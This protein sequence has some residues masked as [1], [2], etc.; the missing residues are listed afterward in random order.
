[1][2]DLFRDTALGQLIRWVSGKKVLLYPEEKPDFQCPNCYSHPDTSTDAP[3]SRVSSHASRPRTPASAHARDEPLPDIET[4]LEGRTPS[5]DEL[6]LEKTHT[7]MIEH[8]GSGQSE[9]S[10]IVSRPNFSSVKSH[11][12]L[13]RTFSQA[14]LEKGP[15]RPI[16]PSKLD[17]GTILVDW[18]TTDD[19]ANPQNWSAWK[20]GFVSF[21]I[22]VYTMAVYM[23]SAIYTPSI[24]GVVQR[25]GVSETAASLG[26]ALYVLAYGIGPLLF[27]PISEIPV[28][29]RNPPYIATFCLFVVLSVPTA[30]VDNF[31]G[32]LVLRF[33]M[34]FFGSPCLATGG[35]SMQDMFNILKLPYM[36]CFWVSAAT[37][38]PALGP[39]IA[40][41]SVAAE[42]WRWSLW[43]ILWL[44]GPIFIL[45]FVALPET[46]TPNILLRRARRLRKLTGDSRLK[47]QSEI[48]QG[49]TKV[50]D[51]V[52]DSLWKP[53]Q[54]AALDPAIAFADFY[55]SLVYAIYYSFFE[56]FPLVFPVMYNFNLGEQGLAF[57]S[58]TVSVSLAVMA[59]FVYLYWW[60]E[61]EIK[62]KGLQ[63]PEKRLVPALYAAFFLPVG[64]FMFGWTA[65]PSVHWIAPIIG[66]TIY[67]FGVF[68]VFQCV[69]IYIPLSYLPYAASLFAGNDFL[70]SALAA[71]A[72]LF[73]RPMYINLGVGAGV[74]LLAGL[75]CVCVGGIFALYIFGAKLRAKSRFALS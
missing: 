33:L 40:G 28:V 67:S 75:T 10:R 13:E 48:D 61:P 18:Y 32:L 74:S 47:S 44:S 2:T 73:S 6:T 12:D 69:F 41:F 45:L 55:T 4:A 24:P 17:D 15:S 49:N 62:A 3:A 65:R 20:K 58:I 54:I 37:C 31:A 51:V 7:D 60:V 53:L 22:C 9:L 8:V 56:V 46:S 43:E 38:G 36:L 23:A 29:G 14:A 34:G 52:I 35:A 64:L 19:P 5:E 21:Q 71:G 68:I 30:L 42:N 11:D 63:A 26:L 66:I 59:Y 16:A 25:F 70:R 72:V 1:M 27:S 50:H 39:V 57:L